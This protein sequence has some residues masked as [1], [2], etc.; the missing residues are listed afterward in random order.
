MLEKLKAC[1]VCGAVLHGTD[2]DFQM[3]ANHWLTLPPI[4]FHETPNSDDCAHD[5]KFWRVFPD[6]LG[7]ELVCAKCGIGGK[8]HTLRTGP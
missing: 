4:F 8:A 7:G 1:P 3:H 5:F 6:G 2:Y